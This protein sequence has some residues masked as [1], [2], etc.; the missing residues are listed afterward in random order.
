MNPTGSG[1]FLVV[2]KMISSNSKMALVFKILVAFV[3]VY[4]AL[5]ESAIKIGSLMGS[6]VLNTTDKE[7]N[8]TF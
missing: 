3:L 5:F 8:N 7:I 6:E 2:K 4:I 1:R